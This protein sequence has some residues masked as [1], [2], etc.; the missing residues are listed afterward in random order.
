MLNLI[1]KN[2]HVS[3]PIFS[4]EQAISPVEQNMRYPTCPKTRISLLATAHLSWNR[5]MMITSNYNDACD[6]I[7]SSY[8]TFHAPECRQRP[9]V[10]LKMRL[11][12]PGCPKFGYPLRLIL[13]PVQIYSQ[14][15]KASS[16]IKVVQHK[17]WR[18]YLYMFNSSSTTQL[19]EYDQQIDQK[20]PEVFEVYYEIH[21]SWNSL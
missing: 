16:R 11:A 21:F 5:W 1:F 9:L 17:Y 7:L 12:T 3:T 10:E 6:W 4:S 20:V 15:P 8:S 2:C 18:C 13:I 14:M 19:R